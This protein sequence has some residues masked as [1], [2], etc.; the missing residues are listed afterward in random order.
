MYVIMGLE[1]FNMHRK[2]VMCLVLIIII[3]IIVLF[4]TLKNNKIDSL[5]KYELYSKE[6]IEKH[7]KYKNKEYIL[8]TYH[9]EDDTYASNNI[10]LKDGN[11]YILLDEIKLCD[12]SYYVL[13]NNIYV[14]CIGKEGNILKYT[15]DGYSIENEVLKLDYS[16]TP[17]IS[18]IHINIDKVDN[19]YI[20]LKSSVKVDDKIKE[21]EHVKCSLNNNKCEYYKR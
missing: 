3:I 1:G 14:H 5:E 13:D 8:T 12:M 16:K 19:E 15:V 21:G 9:K 10:L 7:F 2:R 18:Q 4:F 11:N 20:Y 17:N 6:K